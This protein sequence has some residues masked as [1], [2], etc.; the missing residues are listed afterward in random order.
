M[1]QRFV[2]NT[3]DL[4]KHEAQEFEIEVAVGRFLIRREDGLGAK[5]LGEE[6]AA[7]AGLVVIVFVAGRETL[8]GSRREA[9]GRGVGE[10]VPDVALGK[11]AGNARQLGGE[12]AERNVFPW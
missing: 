7:V 4:L 12:A 10:E 6:V 11:L 8:A 9:E 3:G 2:R 1:D 5:E